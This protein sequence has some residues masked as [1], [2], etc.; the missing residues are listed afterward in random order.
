M[1]TEAANPK[2]VA[3]ICQPDAFANAIRPPQIQRFLEQRGHVVSLVDTYWL[4]RASATPGSLGSKLP[5][6]GLRTLGLY[7]TEV[8]S[9]LLTRRWGFGRRHLSYYLLLADHRLRRAILTATLPLDDFDLIICETSYDAGVLTAKTKARTMYDCPAP[10][11]DELYFEGRLT[12]RQHAALRRLEADVFER[13]DYLAFHWES[14][15]HYA[16]EKYPISGRNLWKLDF[17]CTASP[18]RAQ[19]ADPLR[20]VYLGNLSARFNDPALLSRL[21][22]LYPHIDVY[23]GPPPDPRLGLNY[24]GYTPSLDVLRTYQVGLVTC[25]KDALRQYGFSS[26]HLH[27]LAYGLP[28]LAPAWRRHLDLLRGSVP[29]DEQN[30]VSVIDSLRDEQQWQAVSDEA[31]AQAKRLDWDHTLRPLEDM[32]ATLPARQL[33]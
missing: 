17:G 19:Y 8:A 1:P 33:P 18:E 13:V 30:F 16:R 25:S 23:G 11:A 31:Y 14:Y 27:Y 2:R 6:W 29:Y 21:A 20:I 24:R 10:W 26:K 7:A 9:R 15:A 12:G 32:L 4:S 5:R 22:A 28:V 3:I